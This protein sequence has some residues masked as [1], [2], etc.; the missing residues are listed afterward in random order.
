[1][2]KPS[3]EFFLSIDREVRNPVGRLIP[4]EVL[5]V[6]VQVVSVVAGADSRR[7]VHAQSAEPVYLVAE[8]IRSVS[9][10]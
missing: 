1:M 6:I 3:H 2:S 4:F 9:L 10:V 5:V 8:E 7:Q